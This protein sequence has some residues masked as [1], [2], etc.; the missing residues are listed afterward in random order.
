MSRP[1]LGLAVVLA[2]GGTAR[3]QETPTDTTS[4]ESG[5][6][7]VV[8]EI[9]AD[10][11]LSPADSAT[12]PV[13]PFHPD[14]TIETLAAFRL[15]RSVDVRSVPFR[16]PADPIPGTGFETLA[17][18]LRLDPEIRTRELSNGPTVETFEL[19][20]AGSGRA[21]LRH[22]GLSWVLP[23]TAGPQ[24][25]EIMLSELAGYRVIRGGAAALYGPNA[26]SGA[27]VLDP[28]FPVP[29][30]LMTRLIG[31][32][33]SD[34]Y[35][36]AVFQ[37]HLRV[38]S[39]AAITFSA[40]SRRVEGFFPG[41]KQID[42]QGHVAIQG[43]LPF[44]MQGTFGYRDY[45]GDGRFGGPDADTIGSLLLKRKDYRI[46]LFRPL[47]EGRGTLVE[48]D[49][50][51]VRLENILDAIETREFSTPSIRV[52]TDLPDLVGLLR[53]TGRLELERWSEKEREAG[54]SSQDW[55]GALALRA[56]MGLGAAGFVTATLREDVEEGRIPATHGR[57]EAEL[58]H[59]ALRVFGVASRGVWKPDREAAGS[60]YEKH[61]SGELGVRLE[62]P[63]AVFRVV[64]FGT[65]I[66][67]L[68]PG[69][70]FEE[71]RAHETP[72]GPP[73]GDAEILGATAGVD[74]E[75]FPIP[76]FPVLGNLLFKT[77]YTRQSADNV[78][79]DTRLSGRPRTIWTGEGAYQRSFFSDELSATA[80]GRLTHYGD[81]VDDAGAPVEDLWLTDVV[82]EGEIGDA[83]FF[84]RFNDLLE[85]AGEVE[86]GY[87][88][89]GFST[90]Y[91]ISWR[92]WG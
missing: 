34:D 44:R 92:F 42:R 81:R 32:E 14:P 57:L 52:T 38:R 43:R 61:H 33:G 9:A 37:G 72:A 51:R 46:R 90:T 67:D 79:T 45:E 88:F 76:V 64:G 78:T 53:W 85:R 91:G 70:T 50:R 41:T 11:T 30:E 4:A 47:G 73:V 18:R 21:D 65:R 3:G 5:A 74:T 54:T 1:L 77:S 68:R 36:R 7:S 12:A 35:Q 82:L 25:N 63:K 59:R 28:R 27:V 66:S 60:E 17:D 8:V 10:S 89:P 86:P 87:R 20:G 13:E 29:D 23:G 58:G 55:R 24:S 16:D 26:A 62:I 39:S 48:M 19:R 40:E 2:L 15:E 31:E 56:T 6:D 83:V 84:V 80:R 71:V 22:H 75:L 69:P 49:W